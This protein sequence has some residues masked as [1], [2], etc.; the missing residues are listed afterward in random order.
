VQQ[1]LVLNASYEP[2]NVCTVRRAHVLLYKGKAEVVEQ[3]DQPLRSAT[4]SF[5]W[6]HV[7]RLVHYVRVPRAIQRKISRRALFAREWFS[8]YGPHDAQPLP[9]SNEE[10][11]NRKR[12]S[13]SKNAPLS[14]ITSCFAHSLR[15]HKYDVNSHPSFEDFARGVLAAGYAPA[16]VREDEALC[17]RYP[18]RPLRGL[19][20]GNGREPLEQHAQTMASY[21][22]STAR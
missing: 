3:L 19:N 21:R 13:D 10:I 15:S 22:R 1:V 16:F 2:L 4:S 20:R 7:I 12:G 14:Y 18:P 9:L 8:F 17:K 6:P 11:A 5:V